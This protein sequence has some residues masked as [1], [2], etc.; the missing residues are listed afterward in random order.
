MKPAG[1]RFDL[2]LSR[3]TFAPVD[4]VA[5]AASRLAEGGRV[6]AMLSQTDVAAVEAAAASCGLRVLGN[7]S[8]S[9]PWS[10][11]SRRNLL[12]GT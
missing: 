6:V 5:V 12:L 1:E 10:G 3:A 7:D 4:W 2:L 8:F 9:L 11:A